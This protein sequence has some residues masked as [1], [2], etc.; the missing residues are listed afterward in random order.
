[1]RNWTIKEAKLALEWAR[2]AASERPPIQEIAKKLSRDPATV[3]EFLRRVL[4]K[5]YRPWTEKPRWAAQEIEA[6]Y[7][8]AAVPTRSP[9][10]AKKYVKRHF[11][12]AQDADDDRLPSR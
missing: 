6:L 10:A 7:Y 4:P 1:M 9:A 12:A 3:K 11:T 2:S 8:G 5:G